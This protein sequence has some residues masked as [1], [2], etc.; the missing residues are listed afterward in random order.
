MILPAFGALTGGM[1]AADPAILQALQPAQRIDAVVPA[2]DRLARF[3]LW[4]A[5]A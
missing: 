2:K 5:A 4:Q 1:D 3:T